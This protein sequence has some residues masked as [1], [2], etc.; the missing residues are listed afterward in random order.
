MITT[1]E[2]AQAEVQAVLSD[3][4]ADN[5]EV[6]VDHA[7]AVVSACFSIEDGILAR[8][9]CRIELGYVPRELQSRLGKH[10]WLES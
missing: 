10:D 8:E 2:D 3:A 5:P 1:I 4:T 6:E 9:L 7:D